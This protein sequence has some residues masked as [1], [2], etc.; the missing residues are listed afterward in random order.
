MNKDAE[1]LNI[2]KASGQTERFS[3][4][5]L[6]HSLEQARATPEEIETVT[7]NLY[8]K[9]YEEIHSQKIQQ[10]AY[11]LLRRQSKDHAARYY[12]KK[13]IME[14]GPTGYPFEHLIGEIFKHQGY[15]VE[16]GITM[17]GACVT[18]EVDVVARKQHQIM[19]MECKYRNQA[20][21]NIDVK[22]PLYINSRFQ[23]LLDNGLLKHSQDTFEG[24]IVTNSRFTDDAQT[25]GLC[26]GLNLLSWDFPQ[27]HSL[28]DLIDRYGLYPLTCLN[29]LTHQEK[30]WLL[31][32]N[33]VLAKDVYMEENLLRKAGVKQSRLR[34][35]HAE[36]EKLC[37]ATK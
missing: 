18:H 2:K 26:R 15:R 14:L 6:R 36:G 13:G 17:Q 24:W 10:E 37:F 32:H 31:E 19:L 16:V 34:S 1:H 33:F 35:V 3:E 27:Q 12:L 28:K 7:D 25:Y 29:S 30:Q 9:L 20:G 4:Q 5:K 11:K 21:A 22:T 8:P 23:D